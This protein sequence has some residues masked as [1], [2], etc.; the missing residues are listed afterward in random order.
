MF[1]AVE[2]KVAQSG[3]VKKYILCYTTK[4]QSEETCDLLHYQTTLTKIYEIVIMNV[5]VHNAVRS[6]LC[7]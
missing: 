2:V 7:S 5:S 3:P 1:W 4:A 6:I